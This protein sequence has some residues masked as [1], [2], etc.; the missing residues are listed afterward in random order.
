MPEPTCVAPMLQARQ[1]PARCQCRE[2]LREAVAVLEAQLEV[3][4]ERIM[5]LLVEKVEIKEEFRWPLA[6]PTVRDTRGLT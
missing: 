1:S 2:C 5:E 3:C 6:E 4:R